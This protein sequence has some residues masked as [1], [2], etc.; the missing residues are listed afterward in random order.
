MFNRFPVQRHWLIFVFIV[1][2][3]CTGV[4]CFFWCG[5]GIR[6]DWAASQLDISNCEAAVDLL[7]SEIEIYDFDSLTS[8]RTPVMPSA[9]LRA[10]PKS[11]RLTEEGVYLVIN[12]FFGEEDGVFILKKDTSFIPAQGGDPSYEKVSGRVY[13]YHLSG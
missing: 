6:A 8:D 2:A 13:T 3:C 5:R 9:F 12:S 4:A 1:A 10:D 7:Y 11:M